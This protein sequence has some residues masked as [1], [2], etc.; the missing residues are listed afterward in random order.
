MTYRLCREIKLLQFWD[1]QLR[2]TSKAEFYYS[3][4]L[5]LLNRQHSDHELHTFNP[6]HRL[7]GEDRYSL[8]PSH[9]TRMDSDFFGDEST[10]NAAS[11]A[12]WNRKRV[13]GHLIHGFTTIDSLAK[14]TPVGLKAELKKE[15][16]KSTVQCGITK[17]FPSSLNTALKVSCLLCCYTHF[18]W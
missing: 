17:H 4:P 8:K 15:V 14:V 9:Q 2:V 7:V 10:K 16:D 11:S 5:I 1:Q 6:H 12:M 3:M 13:I 18:S